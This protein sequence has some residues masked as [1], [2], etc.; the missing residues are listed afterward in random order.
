[1]IG[2]RAAWFESRSQ[3]K[4]GLIDEG[5]KV[6]NPS[7]DEFLRKYMAE[8]ETFICRVLTVLPRTP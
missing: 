1:L 4:A 6:T 7:T 2:A 5:F 3:Y 8:F